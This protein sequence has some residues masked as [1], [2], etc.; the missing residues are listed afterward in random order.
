MKTLVIVGA[1]GHG[2]VVADCAQQLGIYQSIIFVDDCFH[3]T[4]TSGCWPIVGVVED[5]FQFIEKSD[6]IVAFG[7]NQLR[8]KTIEMLTK[9][10][11]NIISLLHPSATISPN[12]II[13]KGV[14]VCA[15]AAINIGTH[16]A[17]GCIINTGATIDH[18][19][20]IHAYSHISPGVSIA[21]GVCVGKLSWL[22]IGSSIIE[23]LTL[24]ENTQIG[25]GAVVIESTQANSLYLGV[26]AKRIRSLQKI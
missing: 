5:F 12:A 20:T 6:F 2:R 8:E 7:N 9:A 17:D 10:K 24:A 21:G 18:D 19:C 16:I 15:N 11:A 26:P 23:G 4:K 3:K 14:M 22:G 1:G 25:A 13:G